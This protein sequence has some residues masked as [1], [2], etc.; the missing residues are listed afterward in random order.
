MLRHFSFAILAAAVAATGLAAQAGSSASPGSA[1]QASQPS[2][3][4][5]PSPSTSASA[6]TTNHVTVTGCI[7]RADQATSSAQNPPSDPDSLQYV[8][9]RPQPEGTSAGANTAP[10]PVGTTG[11]EANSRVMYRLSGDQQKLNPHVG[12][13]VEI[14]G[15]P[16][17]MGSSAASGASAP[18]PAGAAP[19]LTVENVRMIDATCTAA[20]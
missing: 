14:T 17:T 18:M 16:S 10:A 13:K 6:S 19:G 3:T 20:K 4:T 15:T 7:E 12:H 2:S 5:S 8:L 1:T 11:T 9:V